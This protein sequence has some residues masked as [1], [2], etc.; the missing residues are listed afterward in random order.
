MKKLDYGDDRVLGNIMRSMLPMLAAQVLTLLYSIVDRIYIGRIP[1]Q[2]TTALGGVGLCFPVII[3]VTAFTNLY[4]MGG[5]P[6]FSIALGRKDAAGARDIIHTAFRL[7]LLTALVLMLLGE[8]AAPAILRLFRADEASMVFA[9]PYLRIYLLGT[10]FTMIATGMNP[11]INAQGF[12]ALG[13]MTVVIGAV[14]N[15]ILDPLFIFA[16]GMGVQGAAL[17]TVLSQGL[18]FLFVLSFFNSSRSLTGLAVFPEKG[19]AAFSNAGSIVSLGMASFVM[20][21]TNALVQVSCNGVL[22]HFG[23]PLYVSVMTIIS[24]VRQIVDTPVMAVGEGTSPLLSYN[25]GAG[26]PRNVRRGMLLMT[27][28][29]LGY[30]AAIWGLILCFPRMFIRIFTSDRELIEAAVP[31]LHIYFFAFIFQ[32]LQV[33]GQT[34][35]K[36]MNKKGRAIFFSLF[37]KVVMVVPL[38]YLLPYAF[39]MGTDGVFMAEPVSNLVGGC[40]C[41]TTM[42]LTILPELGRM[43]GRDGSKEDKDREAAG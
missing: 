8:A 21:F 22:M 28:I 4:G 14:T 24:S 13:M 9:L 41:F 26:R 17:A 34:V 38:T 42:L 40:A 1:G 20:S 2:G 3:M 27:L 23:G 31:A 33:S 25:Y 36:S 6:L 37:R 7:E 43:D 11:Y 30:T 19:R 35:F 15:I 10:V 32:S 18:S 5:A 12:P 29:G 16:L 39:G